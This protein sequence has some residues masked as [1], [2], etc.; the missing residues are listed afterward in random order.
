M[1]HRNAPQARITL[2]TPSIA[3]ATALAVA[4]VLSL[5][6][7]V[8]ARR[9][10]PP[11]VPTGLEPEAGT[12]PYLV[13]HAV[14]TQNYVCAPSGSAVAWKLYTPQA[15]LFDGRGR[16]LTTHFFSPN[17]FQGDLFS[18]VWQHSRDTSSVWTRLHAASSDPAFVAPDAIPWLLLDV[19][20]VAGGP[21][22][23]DALVATT[24]I[25]RL[26]TDGG[27]APATGCTVATDLGNK[28]HVPYTADYYFYRSQGRRD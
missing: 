5:A 19:D 4:L 1:Q 10:A 8:H 15:T 25:Q 3:C 23:G 22:G 27:V 14:G 2:H 9:I 17:P 26:H 28:A 6:P 13:G 12:R 16:Q 11:P 18:P 7:A 20:G 21:S 24:Q